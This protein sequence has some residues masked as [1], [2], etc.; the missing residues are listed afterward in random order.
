M[1]MI[2]F[3]LYFFLSLHWSAVAQHCLKIIFYFIMRRIF[4]DKKIFISITFNNSELSMTR[5][6][7]IFWQNFRWLEPTLIDLQ[8]ILVKS[9]KIKTH[10]IFTLILYLCFILFYLQN[11]NRINAI[12]I[13]HRLVFLFNV[14]MLQ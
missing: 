10:F 12:R 9:S 8:F 7:D 13:L 3:L 2:S 6:F 1:L 11:H 5:T 14:S 4:R